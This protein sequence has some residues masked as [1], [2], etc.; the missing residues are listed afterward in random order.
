MS[1]ACF[2]GKP[3]HSCPRQT[4]ARKHHSPPFLPFSSHTCRFC[5]FR[6]L[7][8]GAHLDSHITNTLRHTRQGWRRPRPPCS[9]FRAG[10]RRSGACGP[11]AVKGAFSGSRKKSFDTNKKLCSLWVFRLDACHNNSEEA[12]SSAGLDPAQQITSLHSGLC[13]T[14]A[15]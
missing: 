15:K 7:R 3:P 8:S 1:L 14:T 10:G 9:S 6:S 11:G 4:L 5:L 12:L 2:Y 13:P